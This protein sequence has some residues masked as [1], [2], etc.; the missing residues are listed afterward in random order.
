MTRVR[1]KNKIRPAVRILLCLLIGCVAAAP[2]PAQAAAAEEMPALYDYAGRASY[3]MYVLGEQRDLYAVGDN[4]FGQ[5]G[6]GATATRPR[7]QARRIERVTDIRQVE[8]GDAHVIALDGSGFLYTWGL[9]RYGQLGSGEAGYIEETLGNDAFDNWRDANAPQSIFIEGAS[10]FTAVA[11]GSDFSLVLDEDGR[12][13]AFGSNRSG[14]LGIGA[15]TGNNSFVNTPTRVPIETRVTD[16]A[17]ADAAAFALTEDGCVYAWGSDYYGLLGSD[18]GSESA[19]P[20]RVTCENG[21]LHNVTALAASGRNAAALTA[22]GTMYV[23][24][25]NMFGQAGNGTYDLIE[26]VEYASPVT[27]FAENGLTIAEIECGSDT[28]YA[29]TEDGRLFGWGMCSDGSLGMGAY[30]DVPD[31][32]KLFDEEGKS[33]THNEVLL[34]CEVTFDDGITVTRM[35]SADAERGFVLCS[36]GLVRSWGKNQYGQVTGGDTLTNVAR[37]VVTLLEFTA[38]YDTVFEQKNYMIKP[39]VGV[40][41]ALALFIVFVIWSMLK[42]RLLDK[43]L[44]KKLGT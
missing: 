11:A 19:V 24:G 44:R 21:P 37:P 8:T 16:I 28:V 1:E 22:D 12:V 34:P 38:Q 32:A 18:G 2:Y 40:C 14:Q 25:S 36:D 17:A 20:V 15:E 26:R 5:L 41:I 6:D 27:Y 33:I 10:R 7:Y 4:T 31:Y 43:K 23:W 13:W 35:L 42:P 30:A 9:N 39:L 3:S 29:R